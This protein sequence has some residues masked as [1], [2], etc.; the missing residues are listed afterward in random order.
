MFGIDPFPLLLLGAMTKQRISAIGALLF[1]ISGS[2]TW[3]NSLRRQFD[4][5]Y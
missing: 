4:N 1:T 3:H 5:T 2:K